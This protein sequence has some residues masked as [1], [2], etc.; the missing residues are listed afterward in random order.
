M[1]YIERIEKDDLEKQDYLETKDD[2]EKNAFHED[3]SIREYLLQRYGQ[4][5]C[6][7]ENEINASSVAEVDHFY[8][9]KIKKGVENPLHD[10]VYDIRNFHISCHRCNHNKGMYHNQ[11]LSPN[12]FFK[13]TSWCLSSKDFIEKNITYLGPVLYAGQD[14]KEF[15][16]RLKINGHNFSPKKG[17]CKSLLYDRAKYLYETQ[18]LLDT[19]V[20]L[21]QI[22][23]KSPQ[24]KNLFRLV[25]Q[26]FEKDA[27]YSTMIIQNL[28]KFFL[29]LK[30]LM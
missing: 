20:Q 22:N 29:K 14:F 1:R 8:P 16:N 24:L 7:C 2:L 11:A 18:T 25:S 17:T 12:Y 4:K 9:Q 15:F 10:I 6:Y 19:C 21:I 13:G 5:C 30:E 3:A 23:N 26:R 28:G 27:K